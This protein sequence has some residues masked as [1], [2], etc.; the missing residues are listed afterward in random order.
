MGMEQ[1]FPKSHCCILDHSLCLPCCPQSSQSMCLGSG[2]SKIDLDSESSAI[3]W[4]CAFGC[5][6]LTSLNLS[7]HV[8]K[9]GQSNSTSQE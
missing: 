6:L 3:Y 9:M 7:F 1:M 2:T 4:L 5:V 8:C